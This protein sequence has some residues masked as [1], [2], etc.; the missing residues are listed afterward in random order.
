MKRFTRLIAGIAAI[1]AIAGVAGVAANAAP[2]NAKPAP[3]QYTTVIAGNKSTCN[4][5]DASFQQR[6]SCGT[7]YTEE[8]LADN[9]LSH[10]LNWTVAV[11]T[12]TVLLD[13][14]F[15]GFIPKIRCGAVVTEF[16][17]LGIH[18]CKGVTYVNETGDPKLIQ[19]MNEAIAVTAHEVSHGLQ[20]HAGLNP[21]DVS[22]ATMLN[23]HLSDLLP[24][25]QSSDCFA[26]A[27]YA[28]YYK[29]GMRTIHQVNQAAA[30][31]ERIAGK[32]DPG[33]GMPKQ[34]R[35]A[36]NK[37][38]D[39]GSGYCNSYFTKYGVTPYPATLV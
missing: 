29:K 16:I 28:L 20:E 4:I 2:A 37:G 15:K 38:F 3:P 11:P 6:I 18:H 34:R 35:D 24:F 23:P 14:V 7:G 19:T 22:I 8:M 31:F 21:V 17:G 39:N 36:F 32:G 10:V 5:V 1:T 25:E 26:G 13:L 12:N 27:V 9:G 30:Y 33:H